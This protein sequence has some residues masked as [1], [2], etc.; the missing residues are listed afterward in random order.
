MGKL[1]LFTKNTRVLFPVIGSCS[2]IHVLLFKVGQAQGCHGVTFSLVVSLSSPSCSDKDAD[3][4]ANI[5]LLYRCPA[6]TNRALGTHGTGAAGSKNYPCPPARPLTGW[7]LPS[8]DSPDM[9]ESALGILPG[10][11]WGSAHSVTKPARCLLAPPP[12]L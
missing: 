11:V 12:N 6:S 10:R 5:W 8:S 2:T 7:S 9:G 1:P 4:E 3:P